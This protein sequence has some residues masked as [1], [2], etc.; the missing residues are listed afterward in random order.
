MMPPPWAIEGDAF[1]KLCTQCNDCIS[2]CPE[3]ILVKTQKGYPQ[4]DFNRGE[5]TFCGDCETAC[6]PN[7]LLDTKQAPWH[8]HA[9]INSQCLSQKGVV[10]R[11]CGDCCDEQAIHFRLAIG[12]FST[13]ELDIEQCTG[14]GACVAPCPTNS[15][16][17]TRKHPAQ[18]TTN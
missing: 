13:P 1:F 11:T 9:Q 4:V 2:T 6:K 18:S 15:I 7:A 16:E 17:M 10:C 3:S 12:G 5:C 8:Y 14:C